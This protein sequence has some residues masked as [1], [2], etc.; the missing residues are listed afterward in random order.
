MKRLILGTLMLAMAAV[1]RAEDEV[2]YREPGAAK[3]ADVKG[4]IEAE[5]PAGITIKT[6]MGSKMVPALDV[7]SVIYE[8]AT[9][10]RVDWRKPAYKEEQA[11]KPGLKPEKRRELLEESLA[12]YRE[13]AAKVKGVANAHRYIQYRIAAVLAMLAQGDT[14]RQEAAITALT[15]FKNDYSSGWEIVP[16]LKLLAQALES[17]GDAAAASKVYEE[18]AA[19]PELPAEMKQDSE[20]Q[21]VRMLLRGG[22]FA[23]A[24][25]KVK[26]LKATL[27][28]GSPQQVFLDICLVQSQ[29]ARGDLTQAEPQLTAVLQA[30]QDAIQR[31]IV[32]NLLGDYCRMKERSEDAFW[33][34]LRV[35]VLYPQDREEHAR[36]LYYLATLFDKVKNDRF[37]SDECHKRLLGPE[38][39]GTTYQRKAQEEKKRKAQEEKK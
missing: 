34:Y 5:S 16:A 24:E 4:K 25:A 11:A 13:V 23:D 33:H 12:A 37:R 21:Q 28:K 39:N 1:A 36:A 18:L 20:A 27:P 32:H 29:M 30:S 19:I 17:K 26:A 31:G 35:D 7:V 8:T 38:F 6:R 2:T 22:K 10:G 15:S 3:D 14:T 9:V